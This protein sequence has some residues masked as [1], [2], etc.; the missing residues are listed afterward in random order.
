LTIIDDNKFKDYSR[1]EIKYVAIKN[2]NLAVAII[3]KDKVYNFP[4]EDFKIEELN[5]LNQFIEVKNLE[6][7]KQ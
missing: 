4:I 5:L 2:N 7:Y 6:E 3:K 1:E